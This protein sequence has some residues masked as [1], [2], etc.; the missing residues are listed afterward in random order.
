M[1]L[2]LSIHHRLDEIDPSEWDALGEADYPFTRH[3]FLNGLEQHDCLHPWGWQPAH[4]TLWDDACLLAALPAYIKDN[5]YGELVFDHAW[6]DAYRRSGLRYYPKLVSAVPYTPATGPRL[7]LR[8]D[9]Q[10]QTRRRMLKRQLLD[11]AI[12]FCQTQGL[13]GWHLLF[14]REGRLKKLEDPRLLLREDCQFHW[15]NPGYGGFDDF[16]AALRS[17]KRKN[18]RRERRHVADSGLR[19]RRRSG[20]ELSDGEWR[21]IHRLY[22]GIFDRKY[23]APTLSADF[24]RHIGKE[25]GEQVLVVT[26]HPADGER[27]IACSLFLQDDQRLYGRIWGS[28]GQHE[29]LHFECCYYQGIEHCIEQGLRHFDPGAQ[30]EHKV[31]RGF[32]P[33]RTVSAHWLANEDFQRL[34]ERYLRAEREQVADYCDYW[35][36]HSPYRRGDAA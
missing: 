6:A 15:H 17:A 19:I 5:S 3:V 36:A 32:L 25:L 24:F 31:P 12:S 22:V 8:R 9:I 23:G 28:E 30:G 16:L 33:T 2:Q 20:H 21:R 7:L 4:F 29:F 1:K 18:I 35:Q 11:A 13:S 27:I 10:D 34:I 26:A 14:E